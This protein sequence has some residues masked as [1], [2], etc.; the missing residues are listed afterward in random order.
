MGFML[1]S[2]LAIALLLY[3][4]T[5]SPVGLPAQTPTTKPDLTPET[6]FISDGGGEPRSPGYWLLWNSCAP[7]NRA[8]MARGNGGR[9]AGWFLV[10]DLLDDPGVYLGDLQVESC[11]Q[12]VELLQSRSISGEDRSDDVA[13]TLAAELT[14]SQLNLGAK[15]ESCQVADEA[16]LGS[17]ALLKSLGFDGHKVVIGVGNPTS[18]RAE[19]ERFLT[20]LQEY[21]RGKLCR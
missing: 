8:E 12:A 11:R 17:Q 16:V 2:L 13:F 21:N 3:G 1:K 10:D 7:D 6:Y 9:E 14:A 18:S 15:A 5:V 4:C 19:V 20:I